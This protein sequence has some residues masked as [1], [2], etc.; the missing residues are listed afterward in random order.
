MQ[1]TKYIWMN[2]ELVDW[3]KATVHVL[4]HALH[5]GS[6]AFEGIRVYKTPNGPAVFRLPEHIE[7]LFYS[8]SALRMEIPYT[9]DQLVEAVVTLLRE[10]GLEQGYIRPLVYYAYG[11]MGLNPKDAPVH[12]AIACW[13]WG[14][15]LPHEAVDIKI[16]KY[17]R[18]HP[19]TTIADAKLCGHYVN[20]IMSAQEVRGTKYHEAIFLDYQ[21]HV[22]EGPGENFFMVKAGKIYTPPTG[23]ILPGITR[24][25]VMQLSKTLNLEVIEKIIKPEEIYQCDEAFFTGTAAEVAP[26]RSIDDHVLGDGAVGPITNKIK[27][28]YL[29]TVYGKNPAFNKFLT[30]VEK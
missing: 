16:S 19:S 12:L 6:G 26:I 30:F 18:I 28:T 27:T 14:A 17:M 8:G 13:P 9:K 24:D 29:D 11:V 3:E 7:R 22:A 23:S 25:T 4:T 15:Y 21:G 5:Y 20:S 10:N 2:G 1:P